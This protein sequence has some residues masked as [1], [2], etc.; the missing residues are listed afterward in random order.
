MNQKLQIIIIISLLAGILICFPLWINER[1][2]PVLPAF[3]FFVTGGLF[4]ISLLALLFVTGLLSVFDFK[5]STHS[6]FLFLLLISVL[7]LQD[8]KRWQ[9][10]VYIFSDLLAFFF[11]FPCKMITEKTLLNLFRV[12][13][14]GIYFW[15]GIHKVNAGFITN[16]LPELVV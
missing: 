7:C 3:D 13:F 16:T 10:W 11:S 12:S 15:S 14:I 6:L 5:Y 4:H 8:Q 2:F 9:P 1:S